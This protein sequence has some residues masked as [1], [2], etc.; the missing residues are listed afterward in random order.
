ML[1][2]Y[3]AVLVLCIIE[4]V[5]SVTLPRGVVYDHPVCGA[6][7]YQIVDLPTAGRCPE[8]G[9]SLTKVGLLT[10]RAAMRLR[11][12]MFGLIVGWTVI[13][14][15]VTFP[16]GGVVMSIMMSG[17]AFGMAGM[18]TSLTKTQTFAPP[19]EWDADAGAYVSAAPYR[20]LFDIDVTTDGIQQRPTTGTIDVSI[21]RGDTKSATLSID[22]EA[23]CE[24]H[25][26][27]GALITT[28]SDF[29]EKAALGLYAEAGLDTSNQQLA[30][31]AAEL[32]ILAQSAMNMPT[33]FE[34][35][36]SMGL[37]VGGTSPGPVFTAQGGQVSL[38]T[39][40]G[41]G[42]TF[43]TVLGVV[44][45]IVLFFLAVYI[46]GLVLLIRRRCRLLAK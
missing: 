21:L 11:G 29:D 12:T 41:T 28:Y 26:S 6:C 30:D 39:G 23:A 32:A 25:A 36:P 27:D 38:Q 16:V 43:G 3:G 24:L 17:A 31:E 9:G 2:V 46:V 37:S 15:T 4:L 19:Q 10:R 33:Y 20:V 22:M 44:A 18:P 34:Q 13:V 5:R 35:M 8:C 14:A 1:G 45:L 42:D 7:N 40:P